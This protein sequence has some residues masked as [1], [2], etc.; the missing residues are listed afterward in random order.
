MKQEEQNVQIF[1]QAMSI[2]LQNKLWLSKKNTKT[3]GYFGLQKFKYLV[4]F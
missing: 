2:F 1:D 4:D 3:N